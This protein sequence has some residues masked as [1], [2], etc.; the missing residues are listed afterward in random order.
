MTAADPF[1]NQPQGDDVHPSFRPCARPVDLPTRFRAVGDR[2]PLVGM[3]D[4]LVGEHVGEMAGGIPIEGVVAN[5]QGDDRDKVAPVA[6]PARA[7]QG[8][9]V[10]QARDLVGMQATQR[11]VHGRQADGDV[12][13]AVKPRDGTVE[14]AEERCDLVRHRRVLDAAGTFEP[15]A[16]V[17]RPRADRIER[18]AAVG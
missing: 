2:R 1:L 8:G 12:E 18:R 9:A 13:P 7:A 4:E 16:E 10:E 6:P 15:R 11:E 17:V 5:A 14:V 3:T